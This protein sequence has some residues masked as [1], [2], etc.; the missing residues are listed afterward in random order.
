MSESDVDVIAGPLQLVREIVE[1]RS[2]R[3]GVDQRSATAVDGVRRACCKRFPGAGEPGIQGQ[4][5]AKFSTERSDV[6][7]AGASAIVDSLSE[8]TEVTVL[9]QEAVRKPTIG[10][11]PSGGSTQRVL[12]PGA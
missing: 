5:I 4:Q 3:S 9:G 10:D 12:H 2:E 1:R 6:R 8:A 7:R 11:R